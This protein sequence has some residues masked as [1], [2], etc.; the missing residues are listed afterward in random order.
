M[1]EHKTHESRKK[2]ADLHPVLCFLSS[3]R[4]D[5]LPSASHGAEAADH[6]EVETVLI[7]L[8]G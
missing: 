6:E 7:K 2:E 3:Y 5:F 4:L 8:R 1:R